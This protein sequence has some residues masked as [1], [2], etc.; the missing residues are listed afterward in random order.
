MDKDQDTD[1]SGDV[2][3]T[4]MQE[5]ERVPVGVWVMVG[6]FSIGLAVLIF[7]SNIDF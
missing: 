2:A 5:G 3:A 4:E 6:I 1:A 7:M